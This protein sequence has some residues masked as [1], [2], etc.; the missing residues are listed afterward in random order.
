MAKVWKVLGIITGIAV[1][2]GLVCIGVGFI[3]GGNLERIKTLLES[4]YGLENLRSFLEEVI[5][6]IVGIN[7]LN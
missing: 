7:P 2:L 4:N 3:T 6:K 5:H 1:L